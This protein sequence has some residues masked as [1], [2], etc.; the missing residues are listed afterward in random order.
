M[1]KSEG[2]FESVVWKANKWLDTDD[3]Q[4]E[5]LKDGVHHW[6]GEGKSV[7][8]MSI[9]RHL[10]HFNRRRFHGNIFPMIEAKSPEDEQWLR[11]CATC[12]ELDKALSRYYEHHRNGAEEEWEKSK[13]TLGNLDDLSST[14]PCCQDITATF[15]AFKTAY[16]SFNV[17]R[18][19]IDDTDIML[20][21]KVPRNMR[22]DLDT[23]HLFLLPTDPI[24]ETIEHALAYN[25]KHFDVELAREWM[26]RCDHLHEE[27]CYPAKRVPLPGLASILLI[28]VANWCVVSA[29]P[30]ARYVALSY[31]WGQT[32]AI[33][34]LKENITSLKAPGALLPDTTVFKIPATIADAMIFTRKA[35][36]RYL[37]VDSLCIIQDDY[38]TK[39][40]HLNS[41]AFIYANSLFTLV[42]ADGSNADHGLH[43]VGNRERDL[44]HHEI[45]LP[46]GT[47]MLNKPRAGLRL[48]SIWNSR[49]WTMQESLFSRRLIIFD[50]FVSWVCCEGEWSE[51]TDREHDY[52]GSSHFLLTDRVGLYG[53]LPLWPDM[54]V[55]GSLVQMFNQRDLTFERDV[56]DAFA[57]VEAVGR[58][59]FPFGFLLGMPQLFFDIA[60]LWQ[61]EKRLVRR[62][63]DPSYYLPSWSW[64]GWKG[65]IE[66]QLWDICNDL[67]YNEKYPLPEVTIEPLIQ[68]RA[69]RL[70]DTGEDHDIPNL[71]SQY[72]AQ[73][74]THAGWTKHQNDSTRAIHYSYNEV[75]DQSLRY[76]VPISDDAHTYSPKKDLCYLTFKAMRSF[77]KIGG[78]LEDRFAQ[79]ERFGSDPLAFNVGLLD[80]LNREV[81]ALR[82]NLDD[83]ND[84]PIGDKCELIALSAGLAVIGEGLHDYIWKRD[85]WALKRWYSSVSDGEGKESHVEDDGRD[86]WEDIEEDEESETYE[87]FNVLWIERCGD[88]CVRKSLGRIIKAAWISWEVVNIVLG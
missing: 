13:F 18:L 41:M 20:K 54:R 79:Q 67:L 53:R 26:D 50:G 69:S 57:G 73:P 38:D 24:S 17:F 2:Y 64:A 55:W 78:I 68:W 77:F 40:L 14:C 76:S 27:A 21:Y 66:T 15:P 46:S 63:K 85:E 72:R 45:R 58:P 42:A 82:L 8:T 75:P 86:E 23:D 9:V 3:I 19:V 37:W 48:D 30:D 36:E 56:I 84:A 5:G 80:P 52:Q 71:Y 22:G 32:A 87:F 81:G 28:D 43:G 35:G 61:P 29:S 44:T 1:W 59:S 88:I 12:T 49:G 33:R 83:V 4:D 31:C 6:K 10:K 25:P 34:S 60:L 47:L 65:E 70:L 7:E 16:S 74:E 51:D 39:E 62:D 11:L